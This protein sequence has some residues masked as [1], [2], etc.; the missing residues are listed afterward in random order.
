MLG[1]RGIV[2]LALAAFTGMFGTAW[3]RQVGEARREGRPD[4]PARD[5]R[6]PS[7]AQDLIGFVTNFFDFLGIGSFATTTATFRLSR[8][9]PDRLIPG[10][11]VVGHCIPSMVQSFISITIIEVDMLTL[12]LL[13]G[14]SMIGAWLGAGV[15]AGWS[16]RKVQLGMGSALLGAALVMLARLT[17]LMPAGGD[18]VGLAGAALAVGIVG[19]F[20]LGALMT[21]GIGAYAPSLILFGL[22]G[23]NTKSI[24]P[25]MMSSCA[26]LMSVGGIRF[27]R[28]GSY[29]LRAALGLTLGG[30]PGV[31]LAAYVIRSLP[32]TVLKWGVLA[33]VVYTA[34]TMLRA[35]RQPDPAAPV[36]PSLPAGT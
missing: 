4:D 5:V 9:V 1:L 18:A 16:R 3:G 6:W 11:L 19:N 29:H 34:I 17:G 2:Y 15:V 20:V 25:I 30:I 23:M 27:L 8:L 33:V 26:F 28:R 36:T 21:I 12:V 32:L 7:L 31:L 10:T 14:A 24:F 13:V 22:L 35:S